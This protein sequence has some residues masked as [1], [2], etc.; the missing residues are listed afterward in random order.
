M[1][2]SNKKR[3][4]EEPTNEV[5]SVDEFKKVPASSPKPRATDSIKKPKTFE[6]NEEPVKLDIDTSKFVDSQESRS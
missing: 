6:H 4:R 2:G 5:A 1:D 3:K